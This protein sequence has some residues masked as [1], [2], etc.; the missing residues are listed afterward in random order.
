[1]TSTPVRRRIPKPLL[2]F[3]RVVLIVVVV[4]LLLRLLRGVDWSEVGY[5]LTHLAGWQIGVLLVA[6]VVRRFV[7]ASPLALLVDGLRPVKAMV[8]DVAATA[9][10]MIAPAPGDVMIRL[11]MLRSWGI[12]TTQ[13]ASGLTLSTLL[14][15]VARLAAPAL[16]FVVFWIAQT[17]Y[18]PFAWSALV[19]GAGAAALLGGLLYALRA[20]RTA[21]ALGR[22][23]G[24]LVQRVRRS[25]R[26]PDAWAH[27]FVTFQ[28]HSA[29][30]MRRRRGLVSLNLLAL[31][32]A[33]AGVL[34]LSL[35]FVG[36][37]MDR[38][39]LL[40]LACSFLVIYPL[41][42]LPL[43]GAGVLEATYVSFVS[44]HSAIETTTLMAGLIV[45]RV[46]VQFVP[47]VVGLLTILI[48]RR[49]TAAA[50]GIT[51]TG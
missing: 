20:E 8:N 11:A 29:G 30:I 9:V 40:L 47:I 18:A 41:T 16:G 4:W 50:G 48:W 12:G 28:Q 34:I 23:L 42:G 33:E 19:F 31:I 2:R 36:V 39:V 37:R 10:A 1:M 43:M 44:D 14:F 35:A 46:A 27:R 21:A 26:G 6:M 51:R 13:A 45:C 3:G 17:F 15:Y 25:S 32:V 38:P 7:V 24:R 49:T 5:G 22:L